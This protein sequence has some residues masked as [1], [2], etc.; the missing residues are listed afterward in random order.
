MLRC[1]S[2]TSQEHFA[3]KR[4][5]HVSPDAYEEL[6]NSKVFD[7]ETEN[8][9]EFLFNF[10]DGHFYKIEGIEKCVESYG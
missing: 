7:L 2:F 10:K 3:W 6:C 9:D 4:L 8:V 5:F 1:S